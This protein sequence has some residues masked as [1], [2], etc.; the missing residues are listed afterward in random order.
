MDNSYEPV[1]P[2]RVLVVDDSPD[3][4]DALAMLVRGWGHDVR[5]EYGGE[6]ELRAA[7]DF[8]PDVC[9]LDLS[10]PRMS[11]FDLAGRLRQDPRTA[12]AVLVAVSGWGDS[13]TQRRARDAGFDAFLLK[14]SDLD[15]LR[16]VL[17]ASARSG[18]ASAPSAGGG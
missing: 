11:G 1:R 15:A 10:M 17:A 14:P 6:Q 5:V 16:G 8:R 18:T 13:E 4:A 9:L 7:L 3:A 12:G 2:R